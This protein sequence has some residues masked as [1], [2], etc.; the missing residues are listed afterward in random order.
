MSTPAEQQQPRVAAGP[1]TTI[2][3]ADAV[4]LATVYTIAIEFI[5]SK[6]SFA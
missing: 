1:V 4:L 5:L 3:I 2:A 6:V